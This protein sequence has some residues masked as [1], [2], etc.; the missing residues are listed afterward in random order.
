M[1]WTR[2]EEGELFT[3]G[4]LATRL[5]Y[6][7]TRINDLPSISVEKASLS[8]E[9]IPSVVMATAYASIEPGVAHTYDDVQDVYP[10]WDTSVGW[11]VINTDGSVGSGA[12]LQADFASDIDTSNPSL[13]VLVLANVNLLE[14][15]EITASIVSEEYFALFALQVQRSGFTSWEH[16][17][18]SERFAGSEMWIDASSG[19]EE[20]QLKM[21]K[22]IP[23]RCLIL[24]SDGF[25]EI[26]KIR[27]VVSV[28]NIRA[29]FATELVQVS[30]KEG[31]ISA[32]VFQTGVL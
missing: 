13:R 3:G 11:T 21:W 7:Q 25:G 10:G 5:A 28:A 16:I 1:E 31:N 9:H 8:R 19:D 30:L 4:S 2:I 15:E 14:I 29:T 27:M 17:A 32:I 22:D 6:A 20:W 26:R 23:I 12:K 18:R 24:P